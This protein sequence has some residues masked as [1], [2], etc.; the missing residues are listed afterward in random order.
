MSEKQFSRTVSRRKNSCG[1]DTP[2]TV[3][4]SRTDRIVVLEE[5][6]IVGIG[7]YNQ[8]MNSGGNFSRLIQKH[9]VKNEDRDDHSSSTLKP[10]EETPNKKKEGDFTNPK[11]IYLLTKIDQSAILTRRFINIIWV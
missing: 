7:S 10:Q 6:K 9:V 8:L 5:G 3:P 11:I 4:F 1:C 2:V